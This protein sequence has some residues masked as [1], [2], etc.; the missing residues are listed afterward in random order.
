[1]EGKRIHNLSKHYYEPFKLVNAIR[2]VAFELELPPTSKIHSVFHV[3]QFKSCFSTTAKT[4]NL[5]PKV[6][7]HQP[8]VQPLVVLYWKQR[9]DDVDRMVLIQW[10]GLFPED[11]MKLS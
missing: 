11:A 4:M 9:T 5:S 1:M 7:E 10:D 6:I 3:F 2:E 8:S